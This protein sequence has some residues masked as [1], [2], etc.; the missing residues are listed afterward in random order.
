MT[1]TTDTTRH[2]DVSEISDL[3]EGLLSPSRTAHVQHHVDG[4]ELCAE[5]HTSLVEIRDLLGALPAPEPMPSDIADRI[6]A[7]LALEAQSIHTAVPEAATDVSRETE[8]SAA[9]ASPEVTDR[10]AGHP[11]AA[12][13][14]GRRPARRRRRTAV[15]GAALGAAVVGVSIFLLQNVQLSQSSDDNTVMDR[16]SS[17]SETGTDTFSQSTLEEQVYD[18]LGSHT[19]AASPQDSSGNKESP[20]LGTKSSPKSTSTTSASPQS[21]LRAPSVSVPSCVEQGIGRNTGA[22]ALERGTYEGADAFLVV[23][24]HPTDAGRV[25]AY[26]VDAACVGAEPPAKGKLLLTHTYARP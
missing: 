18:L 5:V 6:D 4:C 22:L 10:P 3:T 23:L 24:P 7:A 2:P 25:Q 20:S 19:D 14:P 26:V 11:R 15:L 12:T 9:I 16:G 21:P 17:L 1:S 13:G 8:P